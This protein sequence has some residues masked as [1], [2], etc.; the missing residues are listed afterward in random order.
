MSSPPS[1]GPRSPR[2]LPLSHLSPAE[3]VVGQN[4]AR[5][6]TPVSCGKTGDTSRAAA[7]AVCGKPLIHGNIPLR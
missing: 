6:Q 1:V 7:T 4:R 2:S 5:F 3:P